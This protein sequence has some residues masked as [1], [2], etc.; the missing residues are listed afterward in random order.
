MAG[1]HAIHQASIHVVDTGSIYA[2]VQLKNASFV[3]DSYTQVHT[4]FSRLPW[5]KENILLTN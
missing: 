2:V 4:S 3:H 1:M 5:L